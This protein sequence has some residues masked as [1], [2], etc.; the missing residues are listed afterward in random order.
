[1]FKLVEHHEHQTMLIL[2]F[3]ITSAIIHKR[4]EAYV[5]LDRTFFSVFIRR[6]TVQSGKKLKQFQIK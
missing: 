4:T 6:T 1:M 2:Y 3:I 5:L